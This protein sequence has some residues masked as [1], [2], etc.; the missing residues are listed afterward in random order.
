M[1]PARLART[2]RLE[3][4]AGGRRSTGD[5]SSAGALPLWN[6]HREER[7]DVA[8]QGPQGAEDSWIAYP[9]LLKPGVGMTILVRPNRIVP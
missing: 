3:L 5:E 4:A 7:S 9:R 6:H 8:I 2:S 1:A